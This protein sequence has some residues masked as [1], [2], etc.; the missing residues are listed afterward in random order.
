MDNSQTERN[1]VI[2]GQDN[3][4]EILRQVSKSIELPITSHIRQLADD[5]IQYTKERHGRGMSAI[6]F[7]EAVRM[8]AFE[9][10]AGSGRIRIAINPVI[11]SMTGRRIRAE[12]CF[13]IA[14]PPYTA[15][16][17]RRPSNVVASYYDHEGTFYDRDRMTG[18]TAQTFLH[19]F[20]HLEGFT[21]LEDSKYGR[22]ISI[23]N[24]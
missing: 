23:Q 6:Q 13:S 9:A 21:F 16:L 10:P 11:H 7:G 1:V 24:N 17:V 15:V 20:A 3:G 2:F 12:S 22:F 4:A 19:E 18:N 8:F 14:L 5:L